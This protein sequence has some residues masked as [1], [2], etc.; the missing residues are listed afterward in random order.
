MR[1]LLRGSD[2]HLLLVAVAQVVA[3][4]RNYLRR[5]T[6]KSD[7]LDVGNEVIDEIACQKVA[8]QVVPP[9]YWRIWPKL[10]LNVGSL[11]QKMTQ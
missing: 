9:L 5:A 2:H 1:K 7:G 3:K 6:F 11:S 10:I 4:N 8:P